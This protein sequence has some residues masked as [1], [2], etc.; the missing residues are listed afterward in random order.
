MQV[1]AQ[2]GDTLDRLAWRHLGS[3]AGVVETTLEAN[4][5]LAELG[6]VLPIGTV[7]E[8]VQPTGPVNTQTV[9]LWD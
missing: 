4:P 3:T 8:L 6:P 2:Q 9:N 1:R 5:G 7:V